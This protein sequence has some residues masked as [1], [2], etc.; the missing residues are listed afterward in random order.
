VFDSQIRL[1]VQILTS[2]KDLDYV[3]LLDTFNTLICQ[4]G[5]IF[6]MTDK[7]DPTPGLLYLTVD[8]CDERDAMNALR[9][10]NGQHY[11]VSSDHESFYGD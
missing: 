11:S 1:K 2:V 6:A 5:A 3:G 7:L 10:L 8:F 4:F 9:T